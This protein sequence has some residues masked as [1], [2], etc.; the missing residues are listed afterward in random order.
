[1]AQAFLL[2][3]VALLYFTVLPSFDPATLTFSMNDDL[4]RGVIAGILFT[5]IYYIYLRIMP[6]SE[7]FDTCT[8]RHQNYGTR[9]GYVAR[10]VCFRR[11]E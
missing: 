1:M 5:V 8:E 3:I 6:L 7:L 10:A 11:S 4:L 2:P 9:I